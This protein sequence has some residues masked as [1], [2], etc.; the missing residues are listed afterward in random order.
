MKQRKI[1][2]TSALPYAN[3]DIHLGHLMEAIQTDIWVRLQKLRGHDCVYVCADDAHGT[4]IMLS[5]EAQGITPEQLIDR[6]N[7]EHR[8]DYADFL[9]EF[10]NFYSTHA[11]ENQELSESIYLALDANGH[12]ARRNINQLFDPDKQLFLADRYITGTCPKC[13]AADQYGDNCEVCGSTYSPSELINP[14]SA[15]SGA[16]PIEKKSEH[17]F[18]TL[19]AFRDMLKTW[20]RS[21]TLQE[22]VANKL[23][24]WLDEGL[25]E[26]DISR[27]APYFGFEIPTAPGKYFYVWLDAPIGYMASFK[28]LCQRSDYKFDDYWSADSDCEVYHFIGKDIIN[29]HT[30]FWPAILSS[31]GYRTPTAV[32]AHGF[33]TV[34]GT[35]MSKSRG[36]F[37]NARTYLKHLNPEYLRYFLAAKLSSGIDDLDL[38]L[39]DFAQRVNSDLV[40]KVVNIASR[41]AGFIG[42]GFDGML[43]LEPDNPQLLETIQSA[44]QDITEHFDQREFGKAI[45]LIMALADKA[46]QYINDKQPWVIAKADRQSAELQAICSTGINAF[47][48][49]ICYLK[50][51]LPAMAAD[52]EAFLGIEP[53]LWND[54][55]KLLL[56][57]RINKFQPLMTRVENDKVQAMITAMQQEFAAQQTQETTVQ[58]DESGLEP[59]IVFDD[60]ARVD[61]RV[62][63]IITAEHVDGADKLLKLQLDVGLD[64]NGAALT[65]TVFSGIKSAY[66]PED[67]VGQLTVL[68]ANLQPRKMKFG[69]SEGMILATGPGGE[70]IWLLQPHSGAEPGMRI[71]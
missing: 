6:V 39:E 69:V 12:I 46:N 4:A 11:Q 57:H 67:L 8:Q 16:T 14:T 26:W 24:E 41:C 10:D 50:P 63:R 61:L 47:R 1:L 9:I 42:K 7:R 35:K 55:Q 30:L 71:S 36:T 62:A 31:A 22:P 25:Q 66:K 37:V 45:R 48:L 68:V 20:T 65:R 56:G 52:A 17:F 2:V 40:G 21:G 33:L 38:N 49:L 53:L 43:S 29:F 27:D 15:I 19:P 34:D 28:N 23:S 64:R 60:F 13:K 32:F 59:E 54:V 70:D 5:A 44:Q 3:G 58:S 51:V 18:F